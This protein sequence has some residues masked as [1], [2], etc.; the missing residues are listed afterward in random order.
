MIHCTNSIAYQ[1]IINA[2]QDANTLIDYKLHFSVL[3][4]ITIYMI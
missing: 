3:N 4:W 1:C 2:S